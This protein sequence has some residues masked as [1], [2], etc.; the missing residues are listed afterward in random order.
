MD[1]QI[2]VDLNAERE[3]LCRLLAEARDGKRGMGDSLDQRGCNQLA[4]CIRAVIDDP[5][6]RFR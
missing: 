1:E 4:A 5:R 6:D 3:W 2:T